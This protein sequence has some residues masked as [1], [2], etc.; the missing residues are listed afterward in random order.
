MRHS[1]WKLILFPMV[2]IALLALLDQWARV[3][4]QR[5]LDRA[6]AERRWAVQEYEKSKRE[7][8]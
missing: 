1:L 7:E 2:A 4:L 6:E 3:L 8:P 5:D